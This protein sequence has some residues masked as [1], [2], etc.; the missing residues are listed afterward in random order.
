MGGVGGGGGGGVMVFG[1]WNLM[2][3]GGTINRVWD[4]G[5]IFGIWD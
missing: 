3:F 4:F 5:N 1:T 2:G